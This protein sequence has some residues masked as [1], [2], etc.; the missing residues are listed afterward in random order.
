MRAGVRLFPLGL[1]L[2]LATA[3][4]GQSGVK[5][6]VDDLADNRVSGEMMQGSLDLR[7]KVN[8]TGLEKAVAARVIVKEAKDDRGTVLTKK[9]ASPPDFMGREYNNGT[10][11]MTLASPARSASKVKI[12]GSV[13]LYVPSRDPNASV[14]IEKGLA[15]L[16]APL[17]SKSLKA[18]GIEITP[19]SP[20]RYKAMRESAKLTDE[21]I[22]EIRAKGKAAGAPE[23]EIE[24][25]I[26]LAKAFEGLDSEPREGSIF[27]SGKES[28]FKRV[29]RIEVLGA[30]GKPIDV[31]ERSTSTR[32]EDDTLMT[33]VPREPP[34]ANAAVQLQLLTD[35]STMSFPFELSFQLP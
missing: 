29:F 22:A 6:E 5:V 20:A 1:A 19:L 24:M 9:D 30:D 33:L 23:K 13:E 14:T 25:V 35:K 27:L 11:M 12:K 17:S 2:A 34:P 7:L 15:K 31:P 28:A 3:A 10:V 4:F 18:L 21:K 16:D 8:G 26:G 32:G